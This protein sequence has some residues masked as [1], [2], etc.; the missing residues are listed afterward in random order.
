[1][2]TI[3]NRLQLSTHISYFVV[4][5]LITSRASLVDCCEFTN[6]CTLTN[7]RSRI[8]YADI[9]VDCSRVSD[10][11]VL[12]L[13]LI[14]S[15][16]HIVGA[17]F[18]QKF[19]NF[20]WASGWPNTGKRCMRIVVS[21][22]FR[23]FWKF[24]LDTY[25][26][27][28]RAIFCFA[29]G[30]AAWE[31]FLSSSIRYRIF[32][33]VS[34]SSARFFIEISSEFRVTEFFVLWLANRNFYRVRPFESQWIDISYD[35]WFGDIHSVTFSACYVVRGISDRCFFLKA[36]SRRSFVGYS[37]IL[38]F[39]RLLAHFNAQANI[40]RYPA[41]WG[42]L[43]F[44]FSQCKPRTRKFSSFIPTNTLTLN[45]QAGEARNT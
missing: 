6:P 35:H 5:R 10:Y 44:N 38:L 19:L 17:I 29:R 34:F 7:P 30:Y 43:V 2:L 13:S 8:V 4:W 37:R 25:P 32:C 27:S 39:S 9:L 22:L 3:P 21:Y 12:V 14:E 15:I 42:L 1:M 45:A 28:V 26:Y 36:L 33:I 23:K 16:V 18:R 11:S 24:F 31:L 20:T 41:I 40:F